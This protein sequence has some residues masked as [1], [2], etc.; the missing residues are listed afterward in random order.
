MVDESN[1]GIHKHVCC[2]LPTRPTTVARYDYTYER[3]DIQNLFMMSE[4][5]SDKLQVDVTKR[6]RKQELFNLSN[7]KEIIRNWSARN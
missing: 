1:K 7:G 5:P 2:P 4:L 3:N 6:R